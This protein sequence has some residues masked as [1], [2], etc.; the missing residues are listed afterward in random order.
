M[1]DYHWRRYKNYVFLIQLFAAALFYQITYTV[2]A[3]NLAIHGT[4]V[5]ESSFSTGDRTVRAVDATASKSGLKVSDRILSVDGRDLKNERVLYEE[6]RKHKPNESLVLSVIAKGETHRRTLR[7]PLKANSGGPATAG[8]LAVTGVMAAMMLFC[9]LVGIYVAAILPNDIRALILFGLMI[10]LS[11][12]VRSAAWYHFPKTL[13][14]FADLWFIAA[15]LSW[16]I[17]LVCF[18]LYFPERFNWDVKRPW[19]KW[20]FLGPLILLNSLI[21]LDAVS[22]QFDYGAFPTLDRNV[23]TPV[24]NG[25]VVLAL[26]IT[27]F[28]ASLGFK[29]GTAKTRD[30]RRRLRIL[31]LGAGIGFGPLVSCPH[32]S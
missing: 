10:S 30:S 28:F 18:G 6:V 9:V 17:W 4:A 15:I 7:V 14:T 11:Q 19:L 32:G 16:S 23:N 13:W 3:F 29:G 2:I 12:T 22:A 5:A 31:S 25:G 20:L 21:A 24:L 27:F 1:E 26:A 8:D